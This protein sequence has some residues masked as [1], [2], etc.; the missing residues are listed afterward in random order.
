MSEPIVSLLKFA[1]A[2]CT[3]G[4][5]I[6]VAVKTVTEAIV[7]KDS[8]EIKKNCGDKFTDHSGR[9]KTLEDETAAKEK[10]VM[11]IEFNLGHIL[12]EISTIKCDIKEMKTAAQKNAI[13]TTEIHRWMLERKNERKRK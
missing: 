11:K 13:M 1:G 7:K 5:V 2:L 8:V 6:I 9:I 12:E 3:I 4:I 10:R